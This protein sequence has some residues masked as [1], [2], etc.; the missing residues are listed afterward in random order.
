[1][2]RV[3]M[4]GCGGGKV[5]CLRSDFVVGKLIPCRTDVS[6]LAAAL[7]VMDAMLGSGS[8]F[9]ALN[10]LS[11]SSSAAKRNVGL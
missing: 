10:G 3:R 2:Y 1:M 7:L 6:L 9:S 5:C 11:G 4:Y 8:R